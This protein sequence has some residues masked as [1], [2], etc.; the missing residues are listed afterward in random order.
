M[1]R[2]DGISPRLASAMADLAWTALAHP[3]SAGLTYACR[4]L[5]GDAAFGHPLCADAARTVMRIA[6]DML[7]EAE[8]TAG[9]RNALFLNA[10]A[11]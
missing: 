9:N 3:D 5:L 8:A 6:R 4:R 10:E 11:A 7:D 2:A 1:T